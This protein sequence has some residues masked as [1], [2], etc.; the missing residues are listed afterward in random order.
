M[1]AFGKYGLELRW[2]GVDKVRDDVCVLK[3]AFFSGAALKIAE[4]IES[5]NFMDIDLTPQYS[6]V[7]SGYYF[8]R[9]SWDDVEYKDDVV[10]LK[11]S[12]LKS[13]FINE[14]T[15]MSSTDY[16]AINTRDHELDVHAYNLVYKGKALNKEGKEI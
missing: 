13:E 15:N 6:K 8:A 11:N 14:I 4:K 16:I 12:V 1:K 3:G 2:E 7:V 9:L 5:P 10:L